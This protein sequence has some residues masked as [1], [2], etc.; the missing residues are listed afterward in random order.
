MVYR[1]GKAS[2]IRRLIN[3]YPLRI[4]VEE[5][6]FNLVELV[7]L[8]HVGVIGYQYIHKGI[9]VEGCYIVW[10]KITPEE[11]ENELALYSLGGEICGG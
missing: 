1:E 7:E 4:W 3:S 8:M 2:I 9:G 5:S 10:L 6:T 11:A